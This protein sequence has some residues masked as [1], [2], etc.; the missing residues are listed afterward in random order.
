MKA[1]FIGQLFERTKCF[2]DRNTLALRRL[3]DQA[4]RSDGRK[5][6][7]HAGSARGSVVR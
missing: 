4:Y 5:P 7:R 1:A 3:E 6:N 2:V